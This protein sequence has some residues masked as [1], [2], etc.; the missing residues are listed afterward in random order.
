MS[1][2]KLADI[3]PLMVILLHNGWLSTSFQHFLLDVHVRQ[4]LNTCQINEKLKIVNDRHIDLI[5]QNYSLPWIPHM[6][7][8]QNILTDWKATL[9]GVILSHLST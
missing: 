1:H 3:Q 2:T 7:D 5:K 6:I 9:P 8:T 4:Y